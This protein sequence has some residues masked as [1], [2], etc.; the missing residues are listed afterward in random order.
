MVKCEQ[1]VEGI[2]VG[3]VGQSTSAIT[4]EHSLLAGCCC[5]W[6]FII[7]AAGLRAAGSSYHLTA[8]GFARQTGS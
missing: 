6:D 2:C 5:N 4:I 8:N 1:I 3:I 7:I